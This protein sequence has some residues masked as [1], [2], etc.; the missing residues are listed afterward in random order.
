MPWFW[1]IGRPKTMRSLGVARGAGERD[2]AE[3][4]RLGG[5]Q[6]ALRVHPVQDVLEALALLADAVLE[7]HLRARR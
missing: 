3:P 6:D 1:P 5:D 4:D 7:R 2:A